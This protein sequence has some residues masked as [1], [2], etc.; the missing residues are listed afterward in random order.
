MDDLIDRLNKLKEVIDLPSKKKK[1]ETLEFEV[2]D[3]NLWNDQS[4]A[5]KVTQEL[6][7]LKK[8][9]AEIEELSEDLEII[10]TL[11]EEE[12][13]K[14]VEKK[15]QKLELMSYL[16]GD[17]DGKNA[18]ISIH[19][20]QGG[21]EAMDWV[22]MLYRMYLRFCERR[23]WGTET[24]DY[25]AG[26]EAGIKSVTFEVTGGYAY[27]Y[28]KAEAGTHRLVRQSPFNADKLRQ[29]SFAL[30][31]VL[32]ELDEVDFEVSIKDE[33][34]EWQFV[35]SGGHGGQNVNKVST[36]ARLTHIP[37]GIV[38]TASTERFQEQNRKIALNLLRGK[39]W[40][41]EKAKA[42]NEKK[43]L[44]GDYRPASWGTQIRSYVLHPYKMVKDLRTNVET[45]NTDAVLDGEIDEF[46]EAELKL[47][48]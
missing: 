33:E 9:V 40:L 2:A 10:K 17:Y 46:I 26:E 36:A 27:G 4:R 19:A 31:E 25:T 38:V 13:L 35:R 3:P 37:T 48:K 6:S 32:P 28:L 15:L 22:S 14:S 20:G 44:K 29:T 43:G 45:G 1:I 21:T 5:R 39:L 47:I 23:G 11:G 8:E 41:L 42:E 24:V 7:D 30:V 16:S 12:S 34:L 18:L